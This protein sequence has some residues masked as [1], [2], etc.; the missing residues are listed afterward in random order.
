MTADRSKSIVETVALSRAAEEYD[1][2]I[3]GGGLAAPGPFVDQGPEPARKVR[4]FAAIFSVGVAR[5][6]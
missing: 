5:V 6:W 3:L 2:A 4:A 1:V